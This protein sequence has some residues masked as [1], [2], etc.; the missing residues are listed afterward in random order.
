MVALPSAVG[1]IDY[2]VISVNF[3][4]DAEIDILTIYAF[5]QAGGTIEA[6]LY[7]TGH[8]SGTG[9]Q[10][11]GTITISAGTGAVNGNITSLAETIDNDANS[12]HIQIGLTATTATNEALFGAAELAIKTTNLKMT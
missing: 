9:T 10:I 1:A 11:G 8:T 4:D 12:Y 2:G 6:K 5:R 7:K 3:P